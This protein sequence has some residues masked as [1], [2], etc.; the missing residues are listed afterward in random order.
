MSINYTIGDDIVA[1]IDHSQGKFKEGNVFKCDGLRLEQ[2]KCSGFL[3]NI[4]IKSKGRKSRCLDCG[5][6]EES[7]G[8][9]WF[10][11]DSFRKLDH[12]FAEEVTARI[13]E[14]INQENLA[15]A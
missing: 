3:V 14:E 8:T 9:W 1:V 12:T 11:A 13:E 15:G 10:K 2:C 6:R 7:D 4:G 5:H